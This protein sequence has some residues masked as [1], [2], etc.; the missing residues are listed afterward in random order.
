[1]TTELLGRAVLVVE[2]QYFLADDL[3][4][5]LT[6]LG[7]E[8]V[9]PAPSERIALDLLAE[10]D[11]IDLAVLDIDLRGDR[12]FAVADALKARGVPFVFA[13]GYDRSAIPAPYRDVPCWH[14]P[15]DSR[16][17]VLSLSTL[18]AKR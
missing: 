1:M 7:A 17:L 14:K 15:F 16:A 10:R 13:T 8:V 4:R 18:T 3:R 9:G 6:E 11:D 12:V 2:D 5:A